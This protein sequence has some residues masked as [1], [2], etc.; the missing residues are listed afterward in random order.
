SA[1]AFTVGSDVHF[2]GGNYEPGTKE[3]DR[4]LAHELTHVVQA[5]RSGIQ[6]KPNDDGGDADHAADEQ[7]VSEP[8]EP[9]EKEADAVADKVTD[10]LHATGSDKGKK[11]DKKDKDKGHA[12]GGANAHDKGA[13]HDQHAG[14]GAHATGGAKADGAAGGESKDAAPIGAQLSGGVGRKVFR[15]PR[16]EA[17]DVVASGKK[18]F[19]AKKKPP[20]P[21]AATAP[22]T[23]GAAAAPAAA[24]DPDLTLAQIQDEIVNAL[25]AASGNKYT[26]AE[27]ASLA[28]LWAPTG[29]L[30]KSQ[31]TAKTAAANLE[32]QLLTAWRT[33]AGDA[34]FCRAFCAQ[35]PIAMRNLN[36]V[37]NAN[38]T[39][40]DGG[41]AALA[42]HSNDFFAALAPKLSAG[43]VKRTNC[44]SPYF[45]D[46]AGP[47]KFKGMTITSHVPQFLQRS[48]SITDFFK[49]SC[50]KDQ[51]EK[52]ALADYNNQRGT[53]HT[54]VKFRAL[55]CHDD[56]V[57]AY[58]DGK[59]NE[60]AWI[61]SIAQ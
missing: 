13:A 35:D 4:L 21:P 3:G 10:E 51:V 41:A 42:K 47:V 45:N 43:G 9:A 52:E 31:V 26:P 22:P 38:A 15:S 56:V 23:T 2:A 58:F 28:T 11:D 18:I 37:D 48:I 59:A 61:Q 32:Q 7:K 44:F 12:G 20:T 39:Y 6:R 57:K 24:A 40:F 8:H 29:K 17:A 49:Y 36:Q 50:N 55:K 33:A 46:A 60:G 19:R 5:Q 1:K 53:K 25:K 14:G 27:V 30:K 34:G 54:L 16:D